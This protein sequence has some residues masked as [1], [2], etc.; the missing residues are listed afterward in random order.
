V[1]WAGGR[2]V[3]APTAAKLRVAYAP[4]QDDGTVIGS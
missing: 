1:G 2:G 3:P 4:L